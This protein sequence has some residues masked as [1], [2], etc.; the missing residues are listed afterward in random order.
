MGYVLKPYAVD[1]DAL[2]AKHGCKDDQ[3]L[4]AVERQFAGPLSTDECKLA[5]ERKQCPGRPSLRDALRRLVAGE[6]QQ[7]SEG[8]RLW[9]QPYYGY[10]LELLCRVIGRA[11]YNS[12]FESIHLSFLEKLKV[13]GP[14]LNAPPLPPVKD[15]RDF[16]FVHH[17]TAEQ[18][19]RE[20]KRLDSN[21][22]WSADPMI[23]AAEDQYRSWISAAAKAGQGLVAFYR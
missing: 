18:V 11:L 14:L 8:E 12:E 9:Y 1:V 3:F 6:T 7:A 13:M 17:L 19:S 21:R 16:P 4:R 20:D 23:R 2:V 15:P 5:S 22:A 10:A